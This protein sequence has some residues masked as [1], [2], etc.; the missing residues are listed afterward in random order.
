MAAGQAREGPVTKEA[1]IEKVL[2]GSSGPGVNWTVHRA[3]SAE[4]CRYG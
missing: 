3:G 4:R 2:S 1:D